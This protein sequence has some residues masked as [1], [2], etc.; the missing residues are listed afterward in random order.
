M[1]LKFFYFTDILTYFGD[2]P[3]LKPVFQLS[4]LHLPISYE[5]LLK[6]LESSSWVTL[7]VSVLFTFHFIAYMSST[8]S[9]LSYNGSLVFFLLP[10]LVQ[11]Q[12]QKW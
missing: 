1:Y 11:Q 2:F 4:F 8:A 9:P 6:W 3:S 12:N 7:V 10:H 5:L